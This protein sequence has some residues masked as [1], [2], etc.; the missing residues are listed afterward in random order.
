MK[1]NTEEHH[2]QTETD[3]ESMFNGLNQKMNGSFLH[4]VV[5]LP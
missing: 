5:P 3:V 4:C 2:N 1:R